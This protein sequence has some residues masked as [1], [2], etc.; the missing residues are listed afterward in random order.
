MISSLTVEILTGHR[1]ARKADDCPVA[2]RNLAIL[3]RA[4]SFDG[5]LARG[6]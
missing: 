2:L 3:V 6:A 5:N 4:L 1:D